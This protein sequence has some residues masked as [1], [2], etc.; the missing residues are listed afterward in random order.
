[1]HTDRLP[2]STA[3]AKRGAEVVFQAVTKRFG[4]VRAADGI[5]FSTNPGEF[6]T[7]LGPSGSGKS[8]LL[9]LLAGFDS[10]D[11]GEI[12]VDGRPMSKVPAYARNQGIVF[13]SY[14]LFPHMT[15]EQNLAFPLSVRGIP[16]RRSAE[17]IDRA[18]DRVRMTGFKERMPHQLSGGQQ[19]RI[20]LA[21]AIVFDPPLLLMDEPLSALDRHLREEMQLELKALH[22]TLGST[23]V[24]VTHDQ[25]EAVTLSNRVAVLKEGRIVQL[26]EPSV[27]Y[28]RPADAFVAGFIG[29]TNFV[30]STIVL[31]SDHQA[32]VDI[33]GYTLTTEPNAAL[34]A[35]AR[36]L[37]AVRPEAIRL[38]PVQYDMPIAGT[39]LPAIVEQAHFLGDSWRYVVR[40][41][42]HR[43]VAKAQADPL[44]ARYVKGD[45]VTLALQPSTMRLLPQEDGAATSTA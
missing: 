29:E 18:L 42:P 4:S 12:I 37:V 27:I 3:T 34:A 36:V 16:A 7:L 17:L 11:A 5:S 19:Q 22:E 6:L 2:A 30:K 8:T 23:I 43:L 44:S 13:Q 9:M 20:A 40:T 41:G 32:L 39:A 28:E 38:Y 24:Y 35:G 33:G 21:R 45:D 14:A 10:P 1:M 25:Q 26:D 31:Q 15:V